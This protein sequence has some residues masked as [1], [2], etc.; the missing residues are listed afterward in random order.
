MS[1]QMLVDELHR[2]ARKNFNRRQVEMRGICDTL[3]ADLVE[4]IPHAKNNRGMKYILVV[5]NIFS[6]KA[7]AR[8]LKDKSGEKV[9]QAMNSILSSIKHP[10][11]NLHVD[12]GTEFYNSRMNAILRKYGIKIYS[13]YSTKKASIVE[14]FNRTLKNKMWKR[15]S[16]NGSY[17]WVDMLES[18]VSEYN[19]SKHRTI[20]MKPNDV[21]AS[22]ET[23]LLNTVYKRKWLITNKSQPKFRIGD[24]VR[25]SKY[26]HIFEKG[27]TANWTVEVFKIKKIQY[28]NPITYKLIDLHD[29]D[30]EGTI[31]TEELQ[32]AKNPEVY[33]VEKILQ[34]D[35][36]KSY[37][38]WLG[39]DSTHN[40]WIDESEF[41]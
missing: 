26:K 14:R 11:K 29:R 39:F 3:Q 9:S 23:Q 15:F 37:V 1:K 28:T 21:N 33:L 22:N 32:L 13:T 5:I 31:Y 27:Y 8:P 25:L 34:R 19:S 10:I 16:L 17:R 2:A 35:G 20:K 30:V 6:K 36:N 24:H 12:M 7:Y 38:K 4:M 41:D 18:L 40:S